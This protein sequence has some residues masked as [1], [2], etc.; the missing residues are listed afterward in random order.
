MTEA[1]ELDQQGSSDRVE[2]FDRMWADLLPV[3]RDPGTG[4]YRRFAWSAPDL[5]CREWFAA[6]S[7][8]RGLDL[9]VDRNGNQ[10]AWWGDPDAEGPGVVTGS[11]LDSVPDG[12]AYDGPLGIVS[13]FAAID[14]LRARGWSPAQPVGVAAFTDEEGARFGIACTGSRLLTGVLDPDRARSLT[15]SDGHTLAQ[16]MTR[17]GV[18]P[19]HLGP[20]GDTLRRIGTFVELHVE[21][22]RGLGDHPV[23]VA[24]GI[25]PHGRWRLDLTG[26]ANHAGTTR[27]EDRDDPMLR[28]AAAVLA[29]REA[30]TEHD[31]VATI[32]RVS[33]VP[34]GTNAVPSSVQGWLDARGPAEPSVRAIVAEVAAAAATEPVEE[35]W[36]P[37]VRFP[38][39]LRGRVGAALGGVPELPTAAGH[40]AGILADA[41]VPSAMMFV[42][43]PSGVSHSPMEYAEPADCHAGVAALVTVLADLASAQG[44]R[45]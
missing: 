12:G 9:V 33:V 36:T 44:P 41:G 31:A 13:A 39:A 24:A 45:E 21:Q 8:R 23:G 40:D 10:W 15:D 18:S 28:L 29:A 20:D 3:G 2:S 22:G 25:W 43:N 19:D 38:A 16:A 30:A 34:N 35:S 27:L 42:R 4:G 17:A 11:H 5:A 1:S 14:V 37:E 6:E 32:G 26:E 7:A